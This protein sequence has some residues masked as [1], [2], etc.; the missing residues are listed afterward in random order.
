MKKLY[1]MAL[2]FTA[3]SFATVAE[4]AQD[5][6]GNRPPPPPEFSSLDVDGSGY[7]EWSEFEDQQVPQGTAEEFFSMLDTDGDGVVSEDEFND[8][9][10]P[11]RN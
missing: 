8:H 7:I 11:Q 10:P 3:L 4:A 5:R 6:S 2:V 1:S 9:K